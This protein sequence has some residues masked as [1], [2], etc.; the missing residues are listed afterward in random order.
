MAEIII[1]S[2]FILKLH[3]L[4]TVFFIFLI[5]LLYPNYDI[6]Q[7]EHPYLLNKKI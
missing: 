5:L 4:I 7:I 2:L 6:E 1:N 3:I